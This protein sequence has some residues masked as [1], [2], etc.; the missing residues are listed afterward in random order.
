MFQR[1]EQD[2]APEELSEEETGNLPNK[3]FKVT[4][5]ETEGRLDKQ[6]KLDIPNKE[7]ENI[8]NNQTQGRS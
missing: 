5:K 2:K 6:T 3:E 4:I 8:K 7:L 1:K